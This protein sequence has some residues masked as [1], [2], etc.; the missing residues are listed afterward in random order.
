MDETRPSGLTRRTVLQTTGAAIAGA[1]A[2]TG[3]ATAATDAPEE[4]TVVETPTGKTLYDVEDTAAGAYAVGGGGVVLERAA[5][6]WRKLLDGGPTGNGNN[7]YGA[8]TTDDGERLWFV[9]SSGAIG[10]YDVTGGGLN[11]YSAPNDVTNN[12]NDVAV[13][14][15]AGAANVFV[16]GDSGKVYYSFDDGETWSAATPG[17][18]SAINAVD[19][20]GPVS[21][22]VVDGNKTVFATT[23]GTTWE[24]V[25]IPDAGQN[26]YGVD[27]DAGDDVAVAGGGGTVYDYD[28][29]EW[30]PQ[31]AAGTGLR[32]VEAEDAAALAVGGSGG[33][34]RRDADGWTAESTPTGENLKAVLFGGLEAAVG[35][36]GTVIERAG[37]GSDGGDDGS[38]GGNGDGGDGGDGGT[39]G[40]PLARSDTG[41][42]GSTSLTFDVENTDS[43]PLTVESFALATNTLVETVSR[44]GAEVTLAADENGTASSADGFPVDGELRELDAAATYEPGTAGTVDF[45]AYDAGNV[46]LAVE[47]AAEQPDGDYVAATLGFADGASQTFYFAVTNVNS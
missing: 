7:L 6:G 15:E 5:D 12:F 39:T 22:H 23:D 10:E 4:W 24:Q 47:P 46:K 14:G 35:A 38:G 40:G 2:F 44:D 28:G 34:F 3:A 21:G 36:G 20:H 42:S 30:E 26:F 8:D 29:V 32:D 41:T 16:A 17:S 25:G 13:T 31:P 45:G 19:F 43:E 1:A 9:G 18:G 27:G 11:D 33:V 37:D